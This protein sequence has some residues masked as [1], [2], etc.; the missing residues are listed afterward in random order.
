MAVVIGS[1]VITSKS[2][3]LFQVLVLKADLP[4]NNLVNQDFGDHQTLPTAS[5]LFFKYCEGLANMGL[6]APVV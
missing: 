4:I 3:F 6:G 5:G 1:K 2:P